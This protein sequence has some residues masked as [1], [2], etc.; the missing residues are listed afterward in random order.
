[1]FYET[2]KATYCGPEQRRQ[3]RLKLAAMYSVLEARPAGETQPLWEG[4]IYDVSL[5]GMRFELDA[6]VEPGT[7]IAVRGTLPGV[8]HVRFQAT[9]TVVRVHD[10]DPHISP[11]RMAMHFDRFESDADERSLARY[12]DAKAA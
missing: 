8:E 12:L 11:T 10:D 2:P 6:A 9:G 4:H 7:A 3:P 1:M 5:S